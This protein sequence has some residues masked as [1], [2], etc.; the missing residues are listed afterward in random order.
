LDG[1]NALLPE[2][3]ERLAGLR[4]LASQIQKEEDQKVIEQLSGLQSDGSISPEVT[5]KLAAFDLRLELMV[6]KLEAVLKQFN[7]LG[8]QLKDL[9][10]GLVDFVAVRE[11]ELVLLCWKENED[12]ISY[13]H[14]MESGFAGRQPIETL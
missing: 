12:E 5:I 1:A 9:D 4:K 8:C 14:D 2:V 13:W 7:A 10:Q 3:R 6:G 11:D